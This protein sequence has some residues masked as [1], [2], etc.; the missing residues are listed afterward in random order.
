MSTK[1]KKTYKK[2]RPPF[3]YFGSKN[4]LAIELC[5]D[6]PPHNCWVDAF[7]GSAAVT[8]AKPPAPIEI[9]NDID[10]E[11]VNLFR[12]LRNN[13]KRL[14]KQVEL[15]PYA[16]VELILARE[17]NEKLNDLEKARQFLVKAMMAINGSFGSSKGGF[18]YSDS[19]VRN[20]REARVNRW[21][22]LPERLDKVVERLKNIRIEQKDAKKLMERF[23][24]RPATLI[25]LD[26][27][28]LADRI[29]GYQNEANDPNFHLDL[30]NVACRSK[31]MIFLSGYSNEL[32]AELLT[33]KKGWT[34]KEFEVTTQ[35]ANGQS[36][37]RT[38]VLWMNEHFT[39]SM[40]KTKAP[41]I[42]SDKEIE[43][44]KLN[45]ER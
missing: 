34:M 36:K 10:G 26:P 33:E 9:I 8:L 35:G 28:Y 16:E 13:S 27:P 1:T 32:Y 18:S 41:I 2:I 25:Y 37:K 45:P 24:N 43:N 3:G 39:K 20:E 31:S 29:N 14:K 23:V 15:T 5:K 6:L 22:N 30:L 42:L 7:C 12:Q 40:N 38:E 19:Y 21:N 17:S 44:N 4:K 11:I